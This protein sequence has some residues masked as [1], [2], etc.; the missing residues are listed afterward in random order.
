M[1]EKRQLPAHALSTFSTDTSRDWARIYIRLW[2][3]LMSVSIPSTLAQK[4][5]HES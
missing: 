1:I 4:I 5:R 3:C 2:K